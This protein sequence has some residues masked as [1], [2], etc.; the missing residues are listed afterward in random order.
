M[1]APPLALLLHLDTPLLLPDEARASWWERTG[2]RLLRATARSGVRVGLALGGPVLDWL[3]T[4]PPALSSLREVVAGDL[5]ELVACPFYGPALGSIPANDGTDQILSHVTTARRLID[6]RPRGCWLPRRTWDPEVPRLMS[7][8]DIDWTVVEDV[9]IAAHHVRPGVDPWG[10]WRTERG[11]HALTLLANDV[12]AAALR[13]A[14]SPEDVDMYIRGRGTQGAEALVFAWSV[15]RDG[16]DPDAEVEWLVALIDALRSHDVKFPSEL[17][18]TLRGRVYLP[19]WAPEEVGTPWERQLLVSAQADRL[20]KRML[21]VS[22][23]LTRMGKRI[24]RH[25]PDAPDPDQILQARRYLHRAQCATHY[26]SRG[27]RDAALRARAWHDLLRA[28]SVAEAAAQLDRRLVSERVDLR[29]SGTKQVLLRTP[30]FAAVVDPWVGG[31]LTELAYVPA[32]VNLVDPVDATDG[33]ER[34]AF[35]DHLSADDDTV[36]ADGLPS[37]DYRV[38]AVERAKDAAVRTQLSR[39]AHLAGVAVDVHKA[40]SVRVEPRLDVVMEVHAAGPVGA[41]GMLSIDIPLVLGSDSDDLEIVTAQEHMLFDE[42]P[43]GTL[44]D[45]VALVGGG[46][47]ARLSFRP[48]VQLVLSPAPRGARLQVTW[49]VTVA[50]DTP[51]RVRMKL[52]VAPPGVLATRVSSGPAAIEAAPG[53]EEITYESTEVIERSLYGTPTPA[54]PRQSAQRPAGE[55]PGQ[56]VAMRPPPAAPTI[57]PMPAPDL[58]EKSQPPEAPELQDPADAPSTPEPEA[59]PEQ[60]S[61]SAPEPAPAPEA[62]PEAVDAAPQ[63]ASDAEPAPDIAPPALPDDVPDPTDAPLPGVALRGDD[64]DDDDDSEDDDDELMRV[65]ERGAAVGDTMVLQR[66]QAIEPP[67]VPAHAAHARTADAADPQRK[68]RSLVRP[69]KFKIHI[70]RPSLYQPP[71]AEGPT[72]PERDDAGVPEGGEE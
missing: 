57:E 63:S 66:N 5:V 15:H 20:H 33:A 58:P 8:A 40:F 55:G 24:R 35:L 39:R 37:H 17:A 16:E 36:Q 52:E 22:R 21:R 71:A 67:P 50:P 46:V 64:D 7:R 41:D 54:R 31:G 68:G 3:A 23:L 29:T 30:G 65:L 26:E 42:L 59:V 70:P 25:D 6:V 11:G 43:A 72:P 2:A 27:I 49:P 38:V 56:V 44:L 62:E 19:S 14:A 9:A 1:N 34:G 51:A 53:T 12:G 48:A 13:G 32:A 47:E 10:A 4:R 18:Q 61:P 45:D 60:A 69:R 28:E